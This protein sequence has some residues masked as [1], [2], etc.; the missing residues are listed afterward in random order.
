[1]GG[2]PGTCP[3]SAAG[4]DDPVHDYSQSGGASV[5]GGYVYRGSAIPGLVGTYLFS[6]YVSGRIWRL[7]SNGSGGF[8]S[9][10]LLDT[11][12][13]VASFG[14]GND[15]EL[16]VVDLN[17]GGLHKIVAAGGGTPTSPVATL[18]SQTGC[19]NPQ[20][21]SQPATGLVPYAPA[22][23]FWSD[24]AT[25]ERWL[26]IPNGTSIGRGADG[27][28]SFPNGTVL[29]KH[30][31]LNNQLVE[32]RLFMRH[33][34][35]DWAGYTYEWN[36]QRTDATLVQGGKTV[37]VG[38]QSWIFPSGN[39]CLTCHTSAAGF[40]LGLEATQLNHN[41]TYASTGRTANQL[42][43][44]DTITMFSTPLGDPA[45]QPTMPDPF[46]TT[47]PLGQRAR[48]YL[49]TNCAQ[50][51]RPGGAAQSSMDLRYPTLLS[52]TNACGVSP[53]AGDL[54]LG[55]A[56]RIIAPGSA[57]NSVLAARMN[58]RDANGMPPLASNIVDAAGVALIQQW[59]NGLTTCQ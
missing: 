47:A 36:A 4:F 48:A 38:Q 45:L 55:A 8:T 9:E 27:D 53:T 24:N 11:S 54:G 25:K 2:A 7:V 43:T 59:I 29:M 28:F 23:A 50:C 30:F 31:R 41:F 20:N 37:T 16:Y 34:D 21:A 32:T 1:Y 10:Q 58:T 49:H 13:G 26:A 57:A 46:D 6:D 33:P 3:A 35:G 39:D 40:S 44:L 15:G 5:T 17:G 56:A 18:L 52:N 51:H 19:V 22:A 42:R 14:Q 12:L